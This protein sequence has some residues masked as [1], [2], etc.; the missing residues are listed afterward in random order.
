VARDRETAARNE[1]V[2]RDA[3]E[4]IAERR[5]EL[6]SVAGA[7]PY[8]CE[9]EDEACT[10]I[11][12]MSQDDYRTVRAKPLAFVVVPGHPTVGVETE[13]RGDGWVCVDKQGRM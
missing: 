8:L 2:F 7:T 6:S 9:C 11:V 4:Q 1:L 13:H 10:A 3:N 5:D 12:R